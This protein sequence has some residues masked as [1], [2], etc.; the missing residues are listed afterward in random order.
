MT[1]E[2]FIMHLN[3]AQDLQRKAAES[4]LTL[5]LA[6]SHEAWWEHSQDYCAQWLAPDAASG[7]AELL[8]AARKYLA[9]RENRH[10]FGPNDWQP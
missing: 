4:G 10:G 2:V 5:T 3:T 7:P 6:Q 1:T 9:R 8:I